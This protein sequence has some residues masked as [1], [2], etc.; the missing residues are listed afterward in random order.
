MG[1]SPNLNSEGAV[2][3]RHIP[4]C[5]DVMHNTGEAKKSNVSKRLGKKIDIGALHRHRNQLDTIIK[6]L[7]KG[8]I[9]DAAH[10]IQTCIEDAAK[11]GPSR[12]QTK[13]WFDQEC[14][15]R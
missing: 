4:A 6:A 2:I 12:R 14:Y 8:K 1:T 13:P 5:L 10:W 3:R 9:E 11:P 15:H 7:V